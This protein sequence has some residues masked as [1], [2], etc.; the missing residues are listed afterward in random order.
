MI[1]FTARGISR[2]FSDPITLLGLQCPL[3]TQARLRTDFPPFAA[4][5]TDDFFSLRHSFKQL[6][7]RY[8]LSHHTL[9]R[10]RRVAFSEHLHDNYCII[11]KSFRQ[12]FRVKK[13]SVPSAGLFA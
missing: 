11:K 4:L 3:A 6:Q 8:L 1:P 5:T 9:V 10:C 7:L 13:S 2:T 12:S